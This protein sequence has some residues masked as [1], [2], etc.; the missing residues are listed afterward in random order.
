MMQ[1]VCQLRLLTT[2]TESRLKEG[3]FRM[4][5]QENENNQVI[6]KS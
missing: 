3:N 4:N 6:E 1:R 2:N 5:I